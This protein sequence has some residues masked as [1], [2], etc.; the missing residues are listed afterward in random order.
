M[1]VAADDVRHPHIVIVDHHGEHIGGR[2]VRTQQ[3]H[4]VQLN[5]LDRHL[6]LDQV[7]NRR[8]AVAFGA[9]ADDMR[10]VDRPV[11]AVA[12]RT[13]DA[14]RLFRGLCRL[15]LGC[16]L[17]LAHPAAVGVAGFEHRLRDPGMP[18]GAGELIDFLAIPIEAEPAHPVQNRRDRRL[19]RTCAIGILDPQQEPAAMVAREQPVE[20]RGARAADMQKPRR[21]RGEARDDLGPARRRGLSFRCC[22]QP[23][24]LPS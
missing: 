23:R 22:A 18:V 16:D 4:I 10:L 24:M 17:V 5:I 7:A 21:R 13:A 6:A 3:D 14:I 2:A 15:A 11:I 12:P 9:Q 20:Q 8:R 1:I 19:C